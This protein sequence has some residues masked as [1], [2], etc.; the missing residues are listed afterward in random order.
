MF[1]ASDDNKTYVLNDIDYFIIPK[2]EMIKILGLEKSEA[3]DDVISEIKN[4]IK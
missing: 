2:D 4:K 3:K 1:L